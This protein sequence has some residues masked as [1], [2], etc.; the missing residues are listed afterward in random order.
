MVTH[1][2]NVLDSNGNFV[3]STRAQSQAAAVRSAESYY[4]RHP[5]D[6]WTAVRVP[7]TCSDG[8]LD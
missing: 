8:A 1:K 3:T 4:V 5:G 6:D 2:Y 7:D